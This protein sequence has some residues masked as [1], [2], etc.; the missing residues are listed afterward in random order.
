MEIQKNEICSD[1]C[2][3]HLVINTNN[4]EQ[5]EYWCCNCRQITSTEIIEN[6]QGE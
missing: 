1:C 2:S 6:D 3:D 4:T 5:V